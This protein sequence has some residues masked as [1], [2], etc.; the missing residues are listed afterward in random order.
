M[1]S[2]VDEDKLGLAL[3]EFIFSSRRSAL[4][5]LKSVFRMLLHRRRETRRKVLDACRDVL[6]DA[7]DGRD[8]SSLIDFFLVQ[9]PVDLNEQRMMENVF[10]VDSISR[11][12]K[13]IKSE[14]V[15][16]SLKFSALSQLATVTV[17]GELVRIFVQDVGFKL[18]LDEIA[19]LAGQTALTP[20]EKEAAGN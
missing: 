1:I 16:Q 15:E 6:L 14:N 9:S 10:R 11:L 17:E 18:L 12:T 19:L 8:M 5:R 3:R 20:D 2:F 4:S 13:I 7:F